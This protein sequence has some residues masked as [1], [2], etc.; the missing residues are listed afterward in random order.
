MDPNSK[1]RQNVGLDSDILSSLVKTLFSLVLSEEQMEDYFRQTT[2][3]MSTVVIV[4]C[5][6]YSDLDRDMIDHHHHHTTTTTTTTTISRNVRPDNGGMSESMGSLMMMGLDKLQLK[7]GD[8]GNGFSPNNRRTT[9]PTTAAASI[10]NP[11]PM[12]ADDSDIVTA[13]SSSSSSD[14]PVDNNAGTRLNDFY[15]DYQQEVENDIDDGE[16]FFQLFPFASRNKI[17]HKTT[18]FRS[19]EQFPSRKRPSS[20]ARVIDI[21]NEDKKVEDNEGLTERQEL[22]IKIFEKYKAKNRGLRKREAMTEFKIVW[23]RFLTPDYW[24]NFFS[25]SS[26]QENSIYSVIDIKMLHLIFS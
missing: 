26:R 10:A 2:V 12:T 17:K 1:P 24:R 19:I 25:T 9:T 8:S 20:Y 3:S 7:L 22:F 4:K 21:A 14:S 18:T 15:Y 11:R 6:A 23:P 16:T 13:R 5:T